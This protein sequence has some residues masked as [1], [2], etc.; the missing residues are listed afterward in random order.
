MQQICFVKNVGLLW[1]ST[2]HIKFE[3]ILTEMNLCI[4]I[5]VCGYGRKNK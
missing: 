5:R 2:R 3:L 4:L 1:L